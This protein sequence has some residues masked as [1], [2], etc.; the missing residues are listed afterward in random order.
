MDQDL[1]AVVVDEGV[2]ASELV[3]REK[4]LT[5][6]KVLLFHFLEVEDNNFNTITITRT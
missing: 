3:L 4:T 1:E 2:T 6:T 5:V